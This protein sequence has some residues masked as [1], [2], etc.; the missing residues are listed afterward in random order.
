M[1][2]LGKNGGVNKVKPIKSLPKPSKPKTHLTNPIN[3]IQNSKQLQNNQSKPEQSISLTNQVESTP[4]P[5]IETRRENRYFDRLT[6][7]QF[8][9]QYYQ[10]IKDI[11]DNIMTAKYGSRLLK[12]LQDSTERRKIEQ[13]STAEVRAYLVNRGI[14]PEDDND[15]KE[16]IRVVFAEILGFGI[17]E[18]LLHDKDVDEVI[19]Q[20]HDYIQ[21]E[22]KGI[23]T[24]TEYKFPSY[25]AALGV[26]RK[27]VQPLNKTLD[28]ANPNVDG[29]LPDGSRLSASIPPLKADNDISLNI[30]KFSNKVYPLTY[31]A[32]NFQSSTPEMIKFME[33]CTASK[34]NMIISGGTGSGKTTLENS[35]SFAIGDNERIITIED[36]PELRIPKKRVEPYLVVH[37]N[38]EG[39]KPISIRDIIIHSLRKRPDRLVVGECRGGEIFEFLNAAN[40]GH[41][42]SITSIH[43]N[44][45]G[46]A[47]ERMENMMLQNEETK[48]M[49]HDAI[50]QTLCSS[51]QMIIQV[52]RLDDGS[53]KVTQITEV[54]G[55]G[56]VGYDKLKRF[57]QIKDTVPCNENMVYLRDIFRFKETS[58]EKVDGKRIIHGR[59]IAT[60]YIPTFL[61]TL[62][63]KGYDIDESFF[64]KRVLKEV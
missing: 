34:K 37:S 39:S 41:E 14:T 42:G 47:F 59:F 54:L 20:R 17:L 51:V 48:N 35:L 58:V 2:S 25:E 40:T 4:T 56:R 32:D 52:S 13:E 38:S 53:R 21:A 11:A 8:Y 9:C 57:K 19:V 1:K 28:Y 36:T 49:T 27:I 26:A 30:R 24:D 60:G 61:H 46:L 29:Y 55:Y 23:V 64:E 7:T 62:K 10:L 22:I 43:A 31:Y 45:P 18:Y 5:I 6:P 15:M 33:I 16:Y 12:S 63:M 3:T 50:L 44:S